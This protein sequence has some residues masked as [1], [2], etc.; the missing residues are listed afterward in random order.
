MAIF[1]GSEGARVLFQSGLLGLQGLPVS[2][3]DV[4]RFLQNPDS[5]V[6]MGYDGGVPLGYVVCCKRIMEDQ[7]P[8]LFILQVV[9]DGGALWVNEGWRDL[10]TF[11]TKLG[12][13]QVGTM[14]PYD[15]APTLMRR[16]G[17]TPRGV[18]AICPIKGEG[19]AN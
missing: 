16:F 6:V 11:A 14:L 4:M 3:P 17:F 19:Q 8:E 5:Y 15:D 12:C 10:H 18:Y 1:P 13:T 9:G 2:P 7:V